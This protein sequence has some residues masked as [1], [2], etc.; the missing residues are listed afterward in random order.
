MGQIVCHILVFMSGFCG[1]FNIRT[2]FITLK[3]GTLVER[4]TKENEQLKTQLKEYEH[5]RRKGTT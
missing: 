3:Y 4:L 1:A 5:P 2:A